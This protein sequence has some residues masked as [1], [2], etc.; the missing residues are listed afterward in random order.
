MCESTIACED[1]A[2]AGRV[3]GGRCAHSLP[4]HDAGGREVVVSARVCA[5]HRVRVRVT[6]RSC[7]VCCRTRETGQ[8]LKKYIFMPS[9]GERYLSQESLLRLITIMHVNQNG[10]CGA[11]LAPRATVTMHVT[12]PANAQ[13]S[14]P[15]K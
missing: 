15:L 14:M 5:D 11:V 4:W 2:A 3:A 9:R 13:S 7:R 10:L 6:A 8:I 12:R 1:R